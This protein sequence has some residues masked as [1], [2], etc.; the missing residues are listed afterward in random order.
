M[1][2]NSKRADSLPSNPIPNHDEL[3]QLL[4]E[5]KT[6]CKYDDSTSVT[7]IYENI[8][9]NLHIDG[10]NKRTVL[11]FVTEHYENL[12]IR[13]IT[14][15]LQLKQSV[16]LKAL[17]VRDNSSGYAY[18]VIG[19]VFPITTIPNGCIYTHDY[20][21]SYHFNMTL[22]YNKEEIIKQLQVYNTKINELIQICGNIIKIDDITSR[23]QEIC[24]A[25][26]VP[27][28]ILPNV[29]HQAQ[30][31]THCYFVIGRTSINTDKMKLC[32]LSNED[33]NGATERYKMTCIAR[34]LSPNTIS[35]TKDKHTPE[36]IPFF[37]LPSTFPPLLQQLIKIAFNDPNKKVLMN[38][39]DGTIHITNL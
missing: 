22:P 18:P 37:V 15:Q 6:L 10:T 21:G 27:N 20:T 36:L 13:E 23:F 8:T 29:A 19:S 25:I 28:Y 39:Q 1:Y 5:Y 24:R 34:E 7:K 17:E 3:Q 11:E 31:M 32:V 26:S 12:T 9:K 30:S 2:N 35:L 4:I 33:N 38:L 16:V 14:Q